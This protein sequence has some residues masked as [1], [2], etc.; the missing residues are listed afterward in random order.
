VR[1]EAV[2][3]P[4]ERQ[5][6]FELYRKERRDGFIRLFGVSADAPADQLAKALESRQFTRF[7][8]EK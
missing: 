1:A 2:R 4:E 6:I 8:P 7:Y 5:R 3:S